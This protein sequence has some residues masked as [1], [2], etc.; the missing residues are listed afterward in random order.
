[1]SAPSGAASRQWR[2]WSCSVVVTTTDPAAL[3]R[4][5][6]CVREL[7]T[8]VDVAVSRF[9]DD[10]DLATVNSLAGHLVP[11]RPLTARLLDIALNAAAET[12][13]AVTPTIGTAL[14]ALGYDADI[15][16]V[17]QRSA[18]QFRPRPTRGA[19]P[20]WRLVRLLSSP[21]LAGVPTGV[22]LDLGA[23]AKA[24]TA[25]EA[26]RLAAQ[27]TGS[28]VLVS[29]G[30]DLA[31]AGAPPGG[32]QVE[33]TEAEPGSGHGDSERVSLQAGGFATSS[34]L[35]RSWSGRESAP[36]HHLIDPRSGLPA[37]SPWRTTTVWA[38]TALA[39]NTMST[40]LL[41][42]DEAAGTAIATHGLA[43]RLVGTNGRV[44]HLG[45]WPG[46]N[47]TPD[48]EAA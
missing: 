13:G 37:H 20:D 25:D 45:H 46:T 10:S 43:G 12:D 44:V 38:P 41:L 9:R 35:A 47:P 34:T 29:I 36:R 2:A 8:D 40:W 23:T 24:W 3:D 32:W 17:R 31:V 15:D 1:M 16:A 14:R 7:M 21:R 30:G 42:D 28:P 26:A 4:A 33:V 5:C 6:A 11:V 18:S 19:V 27:R 39:A 48:E 22:T